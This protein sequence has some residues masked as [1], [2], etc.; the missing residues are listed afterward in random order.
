[1][2]PG[3]ACPSVSRLSPGPLRT[4]N[5][6]RH[7]AK[8]ARRKPPGQGPWARFAAGD[9]QPFTGRRLSAS[10]YNAA[11][12]LGPAKTRPLMSMA[13]PAVQ[14]LCFVLI[15][16]VFGDYSYLRQTL[17]LNLSLAPQ[18]VF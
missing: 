16:L 14:I 7:P 17:A 2:R 3:N 5:T 6:A 13:L 4:R 8:R 12:G 10:H 11:L 18:A 15:S 9:G 1:M